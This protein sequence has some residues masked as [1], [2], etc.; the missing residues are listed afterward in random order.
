VALL[1]A[2]VMGAP[3]LG[4]AGTAALVTGAALLAAELADGRIALAEL[5][6]L[7]VLG[8][9]ALTAWMALSPAP[10]LFWSLLVVSAVSSHAPRHLRHWRY[11]RRAA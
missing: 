7:V 9:F 3:A 4:W 6:G 8:K 5:A 1:A 2:A 11:G 10:W